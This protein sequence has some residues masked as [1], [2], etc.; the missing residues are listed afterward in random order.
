MKPKETFKQYPVHIPRPNIVQAQKLIIIQSLLSA[1]QP[2]QHTH[3][4]STVQAPRP[5][6][7]HTHSTALHLL[8]QLSILSLMLFQQPKLTPLPS[9]AVTQKLTTIQRLTSAL[10]RLEVL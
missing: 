8:H 6:I 10:L 1:Q 4:R 3:Q 9:I 2:L 7:I 5:T